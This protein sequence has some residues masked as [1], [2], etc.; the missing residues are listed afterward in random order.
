MDYVAVFGKL[1]WF[2][3]PIG[4]ANMAPVLFKFIPILDQPVHARLF[5]T[6]KT[7]RGLIVGTLV[8]G[9][10]YVLQATLVQS[11]S[12]FSGVSYYDYALFPVWFGFLLGGAALLGDLI[13]S[14]FKRRFGI[15]SGDRWFPFDQ[16]DYL[17][18][19]II[20]VFFYV[21]M[22]WIVLE[23]VFGGGLVLHVVVNQIGYRL[24]IKDTPW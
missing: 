12:L 18:L 6:H 1:V 10:I 13:K 16:I 5:G 19:P 9:F 11:S 23:M 22:E 14:F 7:W 2:L 17:I 15:K 3:A 4:F 8:G 21:P 20:V 24:H